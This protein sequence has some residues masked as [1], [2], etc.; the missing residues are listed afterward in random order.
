[1]YRTTIKQP[2]KRTQATQHNHDKQSNNTKKQKREFIL[3]KLDVINAGLLSPEQ[4]ERLPLANELLSVFSETEEE[5]KEKMNIE[6]LRLS[7][8]K[9]ESLVNVFNE[10]SNQIA[11]SRDD[12]QMI[13][14]KDIFEEIDREL[15]LK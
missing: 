8:P 1:M 14:T 2:V 15:G 11:S 4:M 10:D 6:I 3:N 5:A 12:K 9:A 13:K 7:A